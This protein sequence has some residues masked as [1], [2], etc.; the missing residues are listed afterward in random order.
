MPLP[1]PRSSSVQPPKVTQ[2]STPASPPPGSPEHWQAWLQRYGGDY[3]TDAERRAA[4][5]D[6]KANLDTIQAV[7]SQS[8]DMHTAGYLEAHERVASGDADSRDDAETWV[9]GDLN[10]YARADWLEGFRSHF[11]P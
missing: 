2:V 1:M 5:D 7:F 11:E 4:Y 3:T 8:D 9:P 10:D 6:F